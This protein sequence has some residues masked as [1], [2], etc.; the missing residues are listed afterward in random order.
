[1]KLSFYAKKND[2]DISESALLF[3]S[4]NEALLKCYTIIT[5]GKEYLPKTTG[6]GVTTEDLDALT[7][8]LAEIEKMYPEIALVSNDRKS[9]GRSIKEL[10]TEARNLLDQLDDAFEGMVDDE[11][12]LKGWFAIRKIKGRRNYGEDKDNDASPASN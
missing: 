4:G 3:A 8:E 1:M 10:I 12:Y 7:N 9:A 11:E 2:V 5:R 6:Y